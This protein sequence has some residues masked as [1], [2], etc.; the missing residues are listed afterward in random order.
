MEQGFCL[1]V[2]I[3]VDLKNYTRKEVFQY[4]LRVKTEKC[5]PANVENFFNAS[6]GKCFSADQETKGQKF[7]K[8]LKTEKC[9]PHK[10]SF[11]MKINYSQKVKTEQCR[12]QDTNYFF[13]KKPG[14][15]SGKCY[16]VDIATRGHGYLKQVKAELC[17]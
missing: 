11:V 14:K 16:E 6:L 13:Y 3:D 1:E 12:M 8:N 10:A 2:S 4:P 17:K 15:T 7:F 5:R 9:K